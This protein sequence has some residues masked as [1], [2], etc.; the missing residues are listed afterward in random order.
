[1]TGSTDFT[2]DLTRVSVME[3]DAEVSPMDAIL[4]L[5]Y[6]RDQG[7]D[8]HVWEWSPFSVMIQF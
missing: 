7:F 8:A 1:M 4:I 5:N 6:L 3:T 2:G